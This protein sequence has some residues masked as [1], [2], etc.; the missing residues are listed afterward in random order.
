MTG[1]VFNIMRFAVND[2]PGIRT[3]VFLKGCPLSCRWC[4]NP[5]SIARGREIMLREDRCI[6]CGD[7]SRL[8][9]QHAIS[10]NGEG[11]VTDRRLCIGCGRCIEVCY[12]EARAAVGT[13]MTTGEVLAEILKDVP[14]FDESGGGV[15]FSGGEPLLQHEFLS[16]LLESSKAHGIHTTLDTT[17]YTSP[18]ILAQVNELVDLWLYD[19]KT[20]DE[21]AHEEFT[22]VSNRVILENLGRL[23]DW[24]RNVIVRIPLIPGFN[25]DTGSILAIARHVASLK[26][27]LEIHLLPYHRSGV[28]KY[29][30]LG[31]AYPLD[32][33][34]PPSAEDLSALAEQVKHH[35]PNVL[36]GG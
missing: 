36:I 16:S 2:G 24:G 31:K 32:S 26:S 15:T 13:E 23:A 6:R 4:H 20:L 33:R 3:T 19:L 14:F 25:D 34:Q 21:A 10:R 30:R 5:E 22:G 11:F 27:I 28:E 29:A 1:T 9:E 17:G 8:C 7:C 12:A 35:V 18:A